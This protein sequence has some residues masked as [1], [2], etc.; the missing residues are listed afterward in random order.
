MLAL[1]TDGLTADRAR[2]IDVGLVSLTD[3]T[4]TGPA[5]LDALADHLLRRMQRHDGHDDDVALLLARLGSSVA[6]TETTR[7]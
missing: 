6:E 4:A 1:Y 7:R 5:A 3:A 2:D